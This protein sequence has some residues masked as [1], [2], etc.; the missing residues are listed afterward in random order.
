MR[1][2]IQDNLYNEDGYVNL[3]SALDRMEQQYD[4][5]KV[6]PF[7]HELV[8]DVDYDEPVVVMGSN[9]LVK[10]AKAKKWTPGAWT[11]KGFDYRKWKKNL[12]KHLLN[13]ESE[14]VRFGDVVP[15]LFEEFFIRPIHDFKEFAGIVITPENFVAWQ[16]KAVSYGDT[17]NEDTL[18][19]MSPVQSIQREYRFFVVNGEVVTGSLY[20]IGGTVRSDPLVEKEVTDFVYQIMKIWEPDIC[21][22]IDIAQT[23]NGMR[24]I[25]YNNI[26]SSGFYACD[27]Q[28]IVRAISE[29]V[30]G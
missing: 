8:P 14:V 29:F 16:E 24:V 6:I 19:A 23:E 1:W 28:K 21:Y 3:I 2:I 11:A 26:N 17:L 5:V 13:Y 7:A 22:V 25:E 10:I 15:P 9:T 20:K 30:G 18:V 4:I 12:G 27:T